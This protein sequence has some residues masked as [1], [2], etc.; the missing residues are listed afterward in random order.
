M[1]SIIRLTGLKSSTM[2]LF[3]SVIMSAVNLGLILFMALFFTLFLGNE[4]GKDLFFY[5]VVLSFVPQSDAII[6]S[7]L[8]YALLVMT[9]AILSV[10]FT[11]ISYLMEYSISNIV[12]NNRLNEK[13]S[14]ENTAT[15][16]EII[17]NIIKEPSN[18]THGYLI[19]LFT[20]LNKSLQ[21][22]V[23]VTFLLVQ[24]W[25]ITLISSGFV[26]VPYLC[27]KGL[28]SSHLVQLG[29]RCVAENKKRFD[30]ASEAI[31]S[32]KE[33]LTYGLQDKFLS[34]FQFCNRSYISAL[35]RCD[36]IA[37]LPRYLL[38][39]IIVLGLLALFVS[40]YATRFL[41]HPESMLLFISAGLRLLPLVHASYHSVSVMS[42]NRESL[43][44]TIDEVSMRRVGSSIEKA[45]PIECEKPINVSGN[46]YLI[47]GSNGVGKT[48]FLDSKAGIHSDH[49]P[50]G[51]HLTNFDKLSTNRPTY[52]TQF[53]AVF[54]GTVRDNIVLG[55]SY[56]DL[57]ELS[58]KC[59]KF[60]LNLDEKAKN[61]SGGKKQLVSIIRAWYW[62]RGVILMDEPTS[63]LDRSNKQLF[64]SEVARDNKNMYLIVTHDNELSG[65]DS[66]IVPLRRS[67]Q[68]G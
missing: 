48:T 55:A 56:D 8:I 5:Q 67:I 29:K 12:F 58:Q 33:I 18:V 31:A 9:Y 61:L 45:V 13:I 41:G 11:K 24:N 68:S 63:A 39:I 26:V 32:K 66:E 65:V 25:Q 19:P 46:V 4:A 59:D 52:V 1:Q 53:P 16:G 50:Y 37:L 49:I 17:K 22:V 2:L 36:A 43:N 40:G 6:F 62:S 23:T 20:F 64:I 21:V 34:Q 60:G 44:L 54:E 42:F 51:K 7:G 47:Q 57:T 28:T 15:E 14:L 35:F 27:I 3:I 30:L 38:E 10:C